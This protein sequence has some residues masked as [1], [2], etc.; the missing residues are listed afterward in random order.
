MKP[1]VS[2]IVATYRRY[3][4]LYRA[5]LSI[6][7][8]TYS[9]IEIVLVND[10]A[11]SEWNQKIR[12]LVDKFTEEYSDIS[13]KYIENSTNQG[14]AQSRN[15]GIRSSTGVYITFL[16]D[17]DIYL[18]A[19]ID[20][21][22]SFMQEGGFDYS[23]TNLNLYN[24]NEKLVDKRIRTYIHNSGKESLL[25]IHLKYHL[26]GT[27]TLMFKKDYIVAIGGFPLINIGDEFYLMQRA[28]ENNGRFGYL[29]C[30]DVKAY[31]HTGEGGLSSG[32]GKIN[33]ENVLY[34]H[35]RKYFDQISR[36]SVKYIKARHFAVIAYA[37]LRMHS[38]GKAFKNLCL[39]FITSP[40]LFCKILVER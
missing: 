32:A 3:D 40:F 23:I 15:I 2:V 9:P 28:I 13:L 37:Y 21:Q 29:S 6:A 8:Q 12:S 31:V 25:E 19:K 16:D 27:D 36:K 30:C 7:K 24:E 1:L 11:E 22:V 26:T 39:G 10:N 5:L 20:N 4:P 35:K 17:D 33:G 34:E 14:S 38:W 18:P